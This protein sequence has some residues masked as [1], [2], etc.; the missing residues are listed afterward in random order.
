MLRK[1]LSL[2]PEL[3]GKFTPNYDGPYV[4]RKVL[5]GNVLILVEMDGQELPKPVNADS[6]KKY[7][8]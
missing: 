2:T 1:V 8:P 5:P 7:F 6:V 4:V 3:G